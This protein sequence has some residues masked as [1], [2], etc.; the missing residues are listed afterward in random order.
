MVGNFGSLVP[1]PNIEAAAVQGGVEGGGV[2]FRSF[3]LTGAQGTTGGD[4]TRPGDGGGREEA[5]ELLE[6]RDD[7]TEESVCLCV[8]RLEVTLVETV[9]DASDIGGVPYVEGVVVREEKVVIVSTLGDEVELS[10]NLVEHGVLVELACTHES[11][12]SSN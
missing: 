6:L 11:Q 3:A 12:Y 8:F 5:M 10:D 1:T 2:H 9:D 4:K 7:A